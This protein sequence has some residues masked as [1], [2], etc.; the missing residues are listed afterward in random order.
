MENVN[1]R[2]D[3]YSTVIFTL[4]GLHPIFVGVDFMPLILFPY[5]TPAWIFLLAAFLLSAITFLGFI[6]IA[7]Y[8]RHII[9]GGLLLILVVDRISTGI[10]LIINLASDNFWNPIT[11]TLTVSTCHFILS[12]VVVSILTASQENAQKQPLAEHIFQRLRLEPYVDTPVLN[13]GREQCAICLSE[14]QA[15]DENIHLP[16]NHYFHRACIEPWLQLNN[17]CPTCRHI[18]DV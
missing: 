14:F 12:F 5:Y 2:S 9:G 7:V 3:V 8:R 1:E 4:L 17:T 16:C 15:V 18:I 6:I 10:F 11:I 13:T